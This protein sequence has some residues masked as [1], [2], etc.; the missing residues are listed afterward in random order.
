MVAPSR[1][2]ASQDGWLEQAVPDAVRAL[3]PR[4]AV[5]ALVPPRRRMR[6]RRLLLRA[7]LSVEAAVAHVPSGDSPRYLVPLTAASLARFAALAGA[8][9]RL[10]RLALLAR[11]PRLSVLLAL[12]LPSVGLVAHRGDRSL[13]DWLRRLDPLLA[14]AEGAVVQATWR[15]PVESAVLYPFERAGR[16]PVVV[17]VA[18]S[19]RVA[20]GHAAEALLLDRLGEA[21]RAAGADV[22]EVRSARRS[23]AGHLLV[24][25]AVT[26]RSAATLLAGRPE[27]LAD[28]V[29]TVVGWL[30]RWNASTQTRAELDW[31][32]LE[33]DVLTPAERL[34]P[35]LVAG[36]RY[37]AWLSDRCSRLRGTPV[38]LVAAHN[39]LTAWNVFLDGEL[40]LA[41]VDWETAS[42][43]ALPFFDFSYAVV[44]LAAAATRYRDR[45]VTFDACFAPGGHLARLVDPLRARLADELVVPSELAELCFHAC[46]LHHAVNEQDASAGAQ[47]PF[48]EIVQRLCKRVVTGEGRRP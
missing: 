11:L 40:P 30:L 21:A 16:A 26:G 47:R 46:W 39:D 17:K 33:R 19:E 41:V 6:V 14:D 43:H 48:L 4:G 7:G 15:R 29:H 3:P 37:R 42:E 25:T 1:D 36:E 2:E 27:R 9:G 23:G 8:R 12:V 35:L 34:A 13:W 44:D 22:P 38:P 31:E 5:Y 20:A 18:L 45:T 10:K 32:R 24:E 28:V